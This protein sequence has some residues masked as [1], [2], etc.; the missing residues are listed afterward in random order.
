MGNIRDE[1]AIMHSRIILEEM[2]GGLQRNIQEFKNQNSSPQPGQ[3]IPNEIDSRPSISEEIEEKEAGPSQNNSQD[4][5][6]ER[7]S[8]D[9]RLYKVLADEMFAA[10][11]GR[12]ASMIS[13]PQHLTKTAKL[14]VDRGSHSVQAIKSDNSTQRAFRR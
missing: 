4:D 3:E 8:P 12:G 13:R 9:H 1:D 14:L 7:S 11:Q 2:P 10:V 5:N 6:R